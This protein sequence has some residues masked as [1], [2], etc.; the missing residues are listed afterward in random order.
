MTNP[1]CAAGST[2]KC[3][4]VVMGTGLSPRIPEGVD[5]IELAEG[6]GSMPVDPPNYSNQSVVVL[7]WERPRSR[8]RRRCTRRPRACRSTPGRTRSGKFPKIS[9]EHESRSH[10]G[11]FFVGAL[12]HSLDYR[13]T[14]GGFIHGF[15]YTAR[16]VYRGLHERP[17]HEEWP[18]TMIPAL[19]TAQP[20]VDGMLRRINRMAGP[21][22][23][24]LTIWWEPLLSAPTA[25]PSTTRRCRSRHSKSS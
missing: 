6:Y 1:G 5:G 3:R 14:S 24:C 21:C 11:V 8:R 9:G 10:Q 16:A 12:G 23:R 2:V 7:G 19:I 22:T 13:T 18:H 4:V 17:H 20:L 15:R 25:T